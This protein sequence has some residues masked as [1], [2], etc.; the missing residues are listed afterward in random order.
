VREFIAKN[1]GAIKAT[2]AINTM[3]ELIKECGSA[4]E[5]QQAIET[6]A[7]WDKK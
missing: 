1:G 3:S 2:E 7:K 6:L 5:L 4:A